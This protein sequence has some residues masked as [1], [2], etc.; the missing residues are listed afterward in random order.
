M[1]STLLERYQR[2][3]SLSVE[4]L[5]GLMRNRRVEPR[6][7]GRGDEFWYARQTEDDEPRTEYVLIDPDTGERRTA[8]SLAELGVD[9]V[10]TSPPA[11]TLPLSDGR[12]VGR[13]G[14]DLVL[15]DPT[16]G[17]QRR[18]TDDGE[19]HFAW[20][21]LPANSNMVL[22]FKRLGLQLPPVGTVPSPTG[23]FVLTI[24]VDER[25]APL[26][27]MVEN[28]PADGSARPVCHEWPV[29]L[30]DDANPPT[31]EC[32]ILDLHDGTHV[33]V[34]VSDGAVRGLVLNGAREIT[35]SSDETR[36][37]LLNHATGSSRAAL[38]EVTVATGARRDVVVVDEGPL[39]EPNQFLYSLPLLH[40][41]PDSDEAVLFSQ[42]DGWGHLYL[43]D[44][45]TGEQRHRITDGE[46]VVRDLIRVDSERREVTFVAGSAAD[47][48]NPLWRQVFRASLDGG[49]QER[50]TPEPA[51]HELAVPEPD[52]LRLVLA[53]GTSP[54]DSL[55]PSGRFF[56]DHRSTVDNP[57][58]IELRDASD[59]G[60]VVLEL[61]RTDVTRLLD[62]GY[63]VPQQ[64]TVKADDGSTD[65]WGI[66]ALPD[67]PHDPERVPVVELLYAGFQTPWVP[68]CF[69]G[70]TGTTGAQATLAALNALGFAG[71]IVD[72]RGTPGR[73]R[74]FR[75]WTHRQGHTTRGL[76]DHL[77][78]LTALAS[79]PF[80]QLDLSRVGVLGHSFGG[81]NAARMLLLFPGS[82]RAGISSA[83]V[84]DPR[85]V[86]HGLWSWHLGAGYDRSSEEYAGLGNLPLAERLQDE[87]LLSCGE[88]DENAT[89]DH[90]LAM[91]S[92]L[93]RAGKRFDVR[94]WPG[95][96]HYQHGPYVMMAFWDFLVSRLLGQEP[97]RDFVPG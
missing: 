54:V 51:D 13:D 28:V 9:A 68:P 53:A 47:H 55:S 85:K 58:V 67:Q 1:H 91:A 92:A 6:W 46:I 29:A 2:A 59:G 77:T 90:T 96:N 36:L 83:G 87:L 79:G 4:R 31:Y 62:A 50:L 42:A 20:G 14:D 56:V 34:D 19:P 81:Y 86:P 43:F 26:K 89:V 74:T 80:P 95:L 32:R 66:L 70:G 72:G 49:R 78:A 23:R 18:L 5:P 93:M 35:W 44:L 60:R 16:D 88:L 84:H 30:D 76:E 39:Y 37:F 61:E 75:Q 25:D 69:L 15:I 45:V 82:Y 17:A 33:D 11:G 21:G 10:T 57:P 52:F 63:C 3:S 65:L 22:P 38:V 64:V 48:H 41:L 97:P 71:V 40:V 12:L 73:D 94:I 27:H 7:T 24:R 8:S